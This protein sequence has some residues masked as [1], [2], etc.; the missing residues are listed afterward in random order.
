MPQSGTIAD[1]AGSDQALRDAVAQSDPKVATLSQVAIDAMRASADAVV[2]VIDTAAK[3]VRIYLAAASGAIQGAFDASAD[4]E[5]FLKDEEAVTSTFTVEPGDSFERAAAVA[6]PQTPRM[7]VASLSARIEDAAAGA[8][9]TNATIVIDQVADNVRV[10]EATGV[11]F[12]GQVPLAT[13]TLT[14]T[15]SGGVERQFGE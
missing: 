4:A 7:S 12:A 11:A 5:T 9:A 6:L 3:T 15:A 10:R 2:A 14:P 8:P 13:F 1:T